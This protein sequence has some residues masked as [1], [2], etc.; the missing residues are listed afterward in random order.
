MRDAYKVVNALAN[1]SG[2]SWTA[3]DGLGKDSP[4]VKDVWNEYVAVCCA[5]F[6]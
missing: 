3:D 1:Q 4:D 2:I 6:F 5:I